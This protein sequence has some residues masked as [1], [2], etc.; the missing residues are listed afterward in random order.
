[1]ANT[2]EAMSNPTMRDLE[3]LAVVYHVCGHDGEF[4]FNPNDACVP[5]FE[6]LNEWHKVMALL[7]KWNRWGM[8]KLGQRDEVK[9]PDSVLELLLAVSAKACNG[10]PAWLHRLCVAYARMSPGNLDLA[11]KPVISVRPNPEDFGF[12]EREQDVAAEFI[13]R[14]LREARVL[15]VDGDETRVRFKNEPFY[16]LPTWHDTPIDEALLTRTLRDLKVTF[17][18]NR[19]PSNPPAPQPPPP[20]APKPTDPSGP[21][22]SGD[23]KPKY[24]QLMSRLFRA[25]GAKVNEWIEIG[26]KGIGEKLGL[27]ITDR[28]IIKDTL[29]RAVRAKILKCEMRKNSS[30]GKPMIT[31]I[32]FLCDPEKHVPVK[33]ARKIRAKPPANEGGGDGHV[34]GQRIT[35]KF[36]ERVK[37][38]CDFLAGQ[39]S[40]TVSPE[41][42]GVVDITDVP[43]FYFF[44][45]YLERVGWARIERQ[46]R[47]IKAIHL[48][49]ACPFLKPT[50]PAPEPPDPNPAPVPEPTPVPDVVE[51]P[52]VKPKEHLSKVVAETPVQSLVPA[53]APPAVVVCA[54]LKQL[55]GLGEGVLALQ[56][57]SATDSG[58]DMQET[59]LS[60]SEAIIHI[61]KTIVGNAEALTAERRKKLG[62]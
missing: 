18:G 2:E 60:A 62:K 43:T 44:I 24:V 50:P 22:E 19:N 51:V 57:L 36:K 23:Q 11:Q 17:L 38:L 58:P 21:A 33:K 59:V 15:P 56:E 45:K 6:P 40:F 3:L 37:K 41:I 30:R 16:Q 29:S 34:D 26:T 54:Q 25:L 31:H 49:D 32:M 53:S 47:S 61:L 5:H 52:V 48:L 7:E 8:V 20:P 39:R 55:G 27:G 10:K 46:G 9:I 28:F 4:S 35:K 42:R 13:G 14:M 1:M 12:R